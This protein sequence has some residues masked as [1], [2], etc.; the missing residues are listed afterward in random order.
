MSSFKLFHFLGISFN[1]TLSRLRETTSWE[2]FA[3][4]RLS[5]NIAHSKRLLRIENEKQFQR[6]C[7]RWRRRRQPQHTQRSKLI[8]DNS[9]KV[10]TKVLSVPF[11]FF[12]HFE[13]D[14]GLFPTKTV[15]DLFTVAKAFQVS[16][17][18][19]VSF[20]YF[21]Y[22]KNSRWKKYSHQKYFRQ[23]ASQLS[24]PRFNGG[25]LYAEITETGDNHGNWLVW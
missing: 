16:S 12:F 11:C 24:F 23:T 4:R 18:F 17:L 2:H 9:L 14:F 10:H 21:R 5:S 3:E 22:F 8:T 19:I 1:C 13:C 6:L 7:F 15:L 25:D 20:L